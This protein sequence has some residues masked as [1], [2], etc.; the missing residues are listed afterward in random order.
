MRPSRRKLLK[1]A[2]AIAFPMIWTSTT[3]AQTYTLKWGNGIALGHSFN[4]RATEAIK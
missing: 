4:V 3:R 2:G 1:Y